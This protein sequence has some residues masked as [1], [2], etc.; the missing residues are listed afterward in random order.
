M[1]G[2]GKVVNRMHSGQRL[3]HADAS[4]AVYAEGWGGVGAKEEA[5]T[6]DS[7]GRPLPESDTSCRLERGKNEE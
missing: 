5:L 2:W 6:S 7:P 3:T 1:S 4:T